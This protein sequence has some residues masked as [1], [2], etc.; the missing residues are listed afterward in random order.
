LAGA[1]AAL[2]WGCRA[3][4]ALRETVDA[5]GEPVRVEVAEEAQPSVD[6]AAVD[7]RLTAY[8]AQREAARRPLAPNP[9]AQPESAREDELPVEAEIEDEGEAPVA[10]SVVA[11]RLTDTHLEIVSGPGDHGQPVIAEVTPLWRL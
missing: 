9:E 4:P 7:Q 6:A 8:R 10:A 2:S 1:L 11:E 5:D 3:T